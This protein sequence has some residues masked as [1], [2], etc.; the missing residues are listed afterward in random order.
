MVAS[1]YLTTEQPEPPESLPS[2]AFSTAS[3]LTD[4]ERLELSLVRTARVPARHLD[5]LSSVPHTGWTEIVRLLRAGIGT[6]MLHALIGKRGTGKTRAAVA[7]IRQACRESVRDGETTPAPCMYRKTMDL[8]LDIRGTYKSESKTEREVLEVYINVPLLVLDEVQE[9]GGSD[10]ED[11]M[12][13]YVLDRRYDLRK[14]T[15]LISNL[16]KSEFAANVGPSIVSRLTECGT[17]FE[18]DFAS[19]RTPRSRK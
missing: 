6:G 4:R 15:L 18:F 2:P 8:F 7:V 16:T 1:P 13:N 14:D 10:F 5:P 17:V 3:P 9:R 11:R 12:L 19:F